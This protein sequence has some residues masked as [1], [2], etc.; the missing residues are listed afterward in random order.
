M[1]QALRAGLKTQQ[2]SSELPAPVTSIHKV[3]ADGVSVFYR[4]AGNSN[5]PVV[6]LLHGFPSSSFM[7]RE[8]IPRLA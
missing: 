5:S 4:E 2:Q 6:L 7:F 1:N 8:I 3:E